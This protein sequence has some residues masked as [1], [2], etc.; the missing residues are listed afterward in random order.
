[1]HFELVAEKQFYLKILW[2]YLD[3]ISKQ[4]AVAN[5]QI[6][7]C[8]VARMYVCYFVSIRSVEEYKLLWSMGT[9][10]PLHFAVVSYCI[11]LASFL[12]KA[13][14]IHQYYDFTL[15]CSDGAQ[16]NTVLSIPCIY[17]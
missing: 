11:N 16:T 9:T 10:L 15:H 4:N 8:T 17:F 14:I 5:D 1:M 7:R 3:W 13:F 12:I 6:L 2:Y